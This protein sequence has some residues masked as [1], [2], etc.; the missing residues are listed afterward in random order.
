MDIRSLRLPLVLVLTL[1]ALPGYALELVH[2]WKPLFTV[3]IPDQPTAL[4]QE[5]ADTLAKYLRMAVGAPIPVTKEGSKPKGTLLSLGKTALA[6]EAGVTDEGLQFDG[7]RMVVKNG[8]LFLLGRD[9]EVMA[10]P[11]GQGDRIGAQG[12]R[13]VALDFLQRLGF[14]WLVPC[15]MGTHI[16]ALKTVSVPDDLNVT[17]QPPFMYVAGRMYTWGDWSLANSFRKALRL[18]STGGHTWN[19]AVPITLWDQHPEY[20]RMQGGRRIRPTN[21]DHQLCCSNPEVRQRIIDYTLAQLA[22]GFDVVALGQPDGWKPCECEAC[23]AIGRGRDYD[24][25]EQVHATQ[26]KVIEACRQK[27]PDRF[28]H[29]II[30][31]PTQNPPTSFD[32]YPLSTMVELAPPTEENLKFW[33]ERVPAGAT[34][35]VYYMGLYHNVGMAPKFTPAMAAREIKMLHANGVKGIYFCGAGEKWGTEGPTYYVLARLAGNP[36]LDWRAIVEEYCALLYDKAGVTMRQYYDLLYKR[37]D[38]HYVE[39]ATPAD[40]FTAVYTPEVLEKLSGLLA[41]AR[42]QA[43]ADENALGFIRVAEIGFRHIALIARA[44]HLYQAYQIRPTTE[45]LTYLRDAVGEYRTFASKEI[46]DILKKEPDFVQRYFPNATLW[47]PDAAD[48]RGTFANNYGTL[49]SPFTWNFENLMKSGVLPGKDRARMMIARL[50]TPPVMSGA[51]DDPAWADVPWT[52]VSEVSLGPTEASTRMKAGYDDRN[53]Y[54][55]FECREPLID[56]MRVIEYG[57]DGKVFNTECI[58]LF[59]APDGAGQKRMQICLSPTATGKWDGRY[60]Y[61]DDPLHPLN[62]SGGPESAWNPN[63]VHAFQIDKPG[64]RWTLE[65]AFPFAELGVTGPSEG[66]RWRG[67]F[68]RERH[69]WAWAAKYAGQS[70]FFLWAPNLQGTGFPDPAAFGDLFFGRVPRTEK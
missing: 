47:L 38:D 31:G 4:E 23:Q 5:G 50:K 16:P 41:L 60:G 17:Y 65:V 33:K 9:Q 12:S 37:L 20:F 62:L 24:A 25:S 22:K 63:Y 49:A 11:P 54:F 39:T 70:E 29:L 30:Y 51:I 48:S 42:Q 1:G 58:E 18:Y 2:D 69:K 15:E 55:A 52:E 14:R 61:I 36:S 44:M 45:S 27:Y 68:G 21:E 34:V 46:P 53:L 13:R 26:R 67:N 19:E 32:S 57:R 10:A 64:R 40:A 3:V 7:Y 8:T 28:V 66:A 43:G 59:L 56:D 6:R 35:Y